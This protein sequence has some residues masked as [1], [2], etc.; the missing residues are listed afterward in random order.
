MIQRM[1]GHYFFM[2]LPNRL[3]KVFEPP[4]E[5]PPRKGVDNP[6]DAPLLLPNEV[7]IPFKGPSTGEM[8]T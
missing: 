3:W 8:K 5:K 1:I 6:E 4:I 2:V 7:P